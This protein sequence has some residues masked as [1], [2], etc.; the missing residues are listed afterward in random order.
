MIHMPDDTNETPMMF[1]FAVL[2]V[3]QVVNV[4]LQKKARIKHTQ[5]KPVTQ[6]PKLFTTNYFQSF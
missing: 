5:Y 3:Y 4:H 1:V 6:N 2:R